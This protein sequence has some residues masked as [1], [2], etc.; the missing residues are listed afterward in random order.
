MLKLVTFDSNIFI[1]ETKGNEKYSDKCRDMISRV[2]SDFLLV[3]PA[4]LLAEIGNA[5]G[6]NVS[7][8]S[9][10]NRVIEV[11]KVVSWF[12]SCDKEFCKK[13]GITGA[14]HGIYSTDSLYLQTALD[15]YSILVSLDEDD[16]ISR[17]KDKNLPIEI[18]HPRD[19]PY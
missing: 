14:Q 12:T 9:G 1:S 5:V 6:R 11:E 4:V 16:F 15:S 7:L 13:A 10:A 8:K 19:F 3:E 17:L 18:Y 2:G